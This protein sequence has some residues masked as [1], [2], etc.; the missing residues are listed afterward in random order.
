MEKPLIQGRFHDF[1][2]SQSNTVFQLS[3]SWSTFSADGSAHLSNQAQ[4]APKARE[5]KRPLHAV[6]GSINHRVPR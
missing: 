6:S 2:A 5:K 4:G 1:P 3:W